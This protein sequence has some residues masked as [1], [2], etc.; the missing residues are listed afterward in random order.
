M[1]FYRMLFAFVLLT[2]S[3]GLA[4]CFGSTYYVATT[5]ND[6][7]PGTLAQPW[8][9]IQR[10]ANLMVAGDSVLI[11]GGTYYQSVNPTRSGTQS[12]PI[13]YT[14]YDTES[15]FVDGSE[16]VTGWV[17]DSGN[18]YRANVTFTA[19]PKF[20]SVR[21]P[22]GNYGGLVTQNG[23]KLQY[24]MA[25]SPAAVDSPGEYYM[26]DSAS[27]PYTMY[28]CVRDLGQGYDPNNYEM[29]VAKRRK[30]IDLDGGEDWLVVEGIT[31]RNYNDNAVH[32][33]GSNDCEFR[34]L[35]LHTNF[36][37]GIYLTSNSNRCLIERC[38]FWDNGHGGIELAS[39]RRTTVRKNRFLKRDLGDGCGGNGAHLWLGP[40]GALAD[41]NLIENNIAFRTGRDNY[42]GPFI[43]VAGSYNLIRHNSIV[44]S[45]GGTIALLDGGHNTVVNNACDFSDAV[46]GI[47]V[48]PNAVHDSFHFI[49][50][51]C[52]YAQDPTGKYWWNNVRYNSLAAWESAGVQV[53]NFDSLPGFANQDSEDLHLISSSSCIDHGT[54]DSAASDD[55]DDNPRPQGQGFDAGA[56]EFLGVGM[57]ELGQSIASRPWPIASVVRGMLFLPSSFNSSLLDITGRKMLDLHPGANDIRHIAPGVYFI[58]FDTETIT[59]KLIITK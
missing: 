1:R 3:G 13:T 17:Q 44:S 35:T 39:T 27:P 30:G 12:D 59:K 34:S 6:T 28:V 19:D 21:D 25:L 48:F 45:A 15:V 32:S 20:T 23:A 40:V 37:T 57:Q 10:A 22:N 52:F 8:R 46:H 51:N 58:R 11:R 4:I 42:Q 9:T 47:A 31:F 2:S 7:N 26:N 38:A 16:V 18:R 56:Y 29:R 43:A 24:A 36:I 14:A 55:Y 49:K 41:S 53:G 5:G 33:I 54:P 50:G